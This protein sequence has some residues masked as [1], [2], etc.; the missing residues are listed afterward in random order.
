M[1]LFIIFIIPIVE[2]I[3][4]FWYVRE[5][6]KIKIRKKCTTLQEVKKRVAFFL[7]IILILHII[8][9]IIICYCITVKANNAVY[10]APALIVYVCLGTRTLI[11]KLGEYKNALIESI[12]S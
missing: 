2:F 11:D 7:L 6:H 3:F 5:K 10:I 1:T 12:K 8:S 4:F 9:I